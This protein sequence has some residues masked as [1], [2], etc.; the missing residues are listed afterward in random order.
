MIRR[1]VSLSPVAHRTFTLFGMENVR[2]NPLTLSELMF[3]FWDW[4]FNGLPVLGFLSM[5]TS[6]F[7]CSFDAVSPAVTP[8]C[9]HPLPI[10]TPGLFPG[11]V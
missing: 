7:T 1:R 5:L 3:R 11:C 6:S 8:I 4:L 2:S 9:S 10:H